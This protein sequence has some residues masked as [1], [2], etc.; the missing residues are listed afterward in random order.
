MK[1]KNI[2]SNISEILFSALT[3]MAGGCVLVSTVVLISS[4]SACATD[5]SM[6]IDGEHGLLHVYGQLVDSPCQISM[7][8]LEQTVSLGTLASADLSYPGARSQPVKFTVRLHGCLVA[9]GHLWDA[10]T[11]STTWGANQPVVSVSFTAPADFSDPSL[12]KLAGV[13]GIALRMTDSRGHDVRLGSSGVPQLLTPGENALTWMVQAER[14]P[15]P[16][17]PGSFR[18]IANFEM[19]YD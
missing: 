16:L 12:M 7:D 19:S 5:T 11:D 10:Y 2:A 17:T 13:E 4:F 15:G 14:V 3:G 6:N 18:A 9:S 8:S 1:K